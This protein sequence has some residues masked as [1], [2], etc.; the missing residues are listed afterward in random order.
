MRR[1]LQSLALSG[2]IFAAGTT[3]ADALDK[4]T[5]TFFVQANGGYSIYKSEMV[6]SNDTSTTVGYG[7]GVYAGSDRELGFLLNREQ[8]TFAFALN[9]STIDLNWQ[10]MILRWRIGPVYLGAIVSS[11]S[12]W[13]VTAPL[14]TDGDD[15]LDPAGDAVDYLNITS[16]GVGG[17]AGTQFPINK[18]STVY[19]DVVF[20]TT[21]AVQEAPIEDATG[22]LT[23]KDTLSLGSRMDLDLGATLKVTKSVLD[24]RGGFKYRTYEVNVDGQ[25]FKEGLNT[26]YVGLQGSWFF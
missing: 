9:S 18:R 14:D 24:V 2:G 8:S 23:K 15:V 16:T 26:T 19:M 17:N 21:Q 4:D 12:A 5:P 1:I 22:A 6:Q 7:F 13:I 3:R 10:D 20:V 11:S 25:A